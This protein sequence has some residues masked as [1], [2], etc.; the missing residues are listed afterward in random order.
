V[1]WHKLCKVEKSAPYIIPL[2]CLSLC[3]K[4]SK[5]VT[6]LWRKQFWLFFTETRCT[7]LGL[8]CG[9]Y[10]LSNM[11]RPETFGITLIYS[12]NLYASCKNDTHNTLSVEINFAS[13]RT[14]G[15]ESLDERR[16]FSGLRSQCTMERGLAWRYCSARRICKHDAHQPTTNDKYCSLQGGPIKSQRFNYHT[17]IWRQT[18]CKTPHTYTDWTTVISAIINAQFTVLI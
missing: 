17:S 18:N 16:T 4:L 3:Q 6:K 7:C 2:S 5:L 9:K 11:S 15:K 10:F 8:D 1:R 13:K 12:C 14:W